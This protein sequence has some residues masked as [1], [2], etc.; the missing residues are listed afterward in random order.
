MN[1]LQ[2]TRVVVIDDEFLEAEPLLRGLARLGI[3]ALYFNGEEFPE[4]LITGTRLVFLD[5]HLSGA[6][7]GAHGAILKSVGV[8]SQVVPEITGEVGVICWTKHSDEV[9]DF[10]ATLKER[11]PK[12]EPAFV[13]GLPKAEFLKPREDAFARLLVGVDGIFSEARLKVPT[14]NEGELRGALEVLSSIKDRIVEAIKACAKT[15]HEP[16]QA[17]IDALHKRVKKTFK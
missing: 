6:A 13:M 10:A 3:G 5:L 14:A 9:K 1:G 16:G 12:F 7:G 15:V 17:D 11:W 4:S 8:L 2:T